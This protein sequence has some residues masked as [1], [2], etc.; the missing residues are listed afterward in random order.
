MCGYVLV[1]GERDK[2]LDG[3]VYNGFMVVDG[4]YGVVENIVVCVVG[5]DEV[6][7]LFV[8]DFVSVVYDVV[9]NVCVNIVEIFYGMCFLFIDWCDVGIVMLFNLED[10]SFFF[11]GVVVCV[12]W[13]WFIIIIVVVD[14][15]WGFLWCGWL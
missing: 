5:V 2:L 7:V 4:V 14:V 10:S 13:R 8:L 6:D 11:D 15:V 9:D 12:F 1:F 3:V